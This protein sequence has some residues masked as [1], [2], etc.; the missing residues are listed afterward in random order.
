[1]KYITSRTVIHSLKNRA[2][3]SFALRGFAM[4]GLPTEIFLVVRVST[5][6][7]VRQE[8]LDDADRQSRQHGA[9]FLFAHDALLS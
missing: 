4:L 1:M 2:N 7:G 5:A 9:F 3:E 6:C 8:F